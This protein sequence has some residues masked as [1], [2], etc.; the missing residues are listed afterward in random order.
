MHIW[1]KMRNFLRNWDASRALCNFTNIWE[2]KLF[3]NMWYEEIDSYVFWSLRSDKAHYPIQTSSFDS[4][5]RPER[6]SHRIEHRERELLAEWWWMW[7]S[8][9]FVVCVRKFSRQ[10]FISRKHLKTQSKKE[11]SITREC[12]VSWIEKKIRSL[13]VVHFCRI[14]VTWKLGMDW[15]FL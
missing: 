3:V 1:M 8:R 5:S 6:F 14:T 7:T 2:K 13:H 10:F 9:L 12:A 15:R 4:F 11:M